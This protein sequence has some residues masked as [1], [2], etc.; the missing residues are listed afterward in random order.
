MH[1]NILKIFLIILLD[2]MDE[3]L[4]L[5]YKDCCTELYSDIAE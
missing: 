2:A 1:K 3:A 5:G 4:P